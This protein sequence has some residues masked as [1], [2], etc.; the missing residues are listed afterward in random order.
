M[1]PPGT[2]HDHEPRVD[3]GQL[4]PELGN[5]SWPR[6]PPPAAEKRGFA[7]KLVGVAIPAHGYHYE[8]PIHPGGPY[9]VP[10][11][12]RSCTLRNRWWVSI[13]PNPDQSGSPWR[14]HKLHGGSGASPVRWSTPVDKGGGAAGDPVAG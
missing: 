13:P 3:T 6:E 14:L 8:P 10:R 9:P 2:F 11:R 12:S 4:L 7:A 5:D 1:C